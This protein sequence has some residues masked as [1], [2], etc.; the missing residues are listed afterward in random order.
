MSEIEIGKSIIENP[1]DLTSWFLLLIVIGIGIVNYFKNRSLGNKIEAFKSELNKKEVKFTRHTELQIE[2]LKKFYDHLVTVDY[3]FHKINK[4]EKHQQLKDYIKDSKKTFVDLI[5]YTH[6]NKILLTEE[7]VD[8]FIILHEKFLLWSEI[9]SIDY[10]DLI[11]REENERSADPNR[12]YGNEQLEF[13]SIKDKIEKIYSNKD[14]K[15]IRQDLSKLRSL[16]EDYFKD[17]VK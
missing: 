4:V 9:T 8:Q 17:L 12:I 13:E 16:V 11:W 1:G 3:S 14:I 15:D 2:C 5:F 7:M 6:R 10:D